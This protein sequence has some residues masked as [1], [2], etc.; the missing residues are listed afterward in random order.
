MYKKK[1]GVKSWSGVGDRNVH[2]LYRQEK[3]ESMQTAVGLFSL[4]RGF[5]L[6]DRSYYTLE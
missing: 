6:V 5:A 2:N 3:K 1:N 4:L